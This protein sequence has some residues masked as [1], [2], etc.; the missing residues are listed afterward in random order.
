MQPDATSLMAAL[1]A[2]EVSSSQI[3]RDCL[4]AVE[5]ADRGAFTH[6]DHTH[7]PQLA[8]Q[9]DTRRARGE[10]AG[11]LEGLPVAIKA[12]IAVAGWPHTAGLRFRRDVI[13]PRDAFVVQRLRA[14]GAIPIGLTNMDEGALGAEGMNPWY[15]VIQNPLRRGHSAGGSSGGSGAAVAAGL[16]PV[17]LG[18]DTIGSVRI[19]ASFCGCFG[20]KPSYG[21]V[22]VQDVVPVHL[23]FDHVGPIARSARDL[24][25]LLH[26]LAA[27][28]PACKVSLA[29]RL[30]PA[31][32]TLR[33][34]RVGF[35]IGLEPFHVEDAVQAGFALA[36]DAARGAGADLVPVDLSRWD[37]PRLR[38]AIL[39]L[40]EVQMWRTHGERITAHPDDFSDGLRAFIR[41]G[42]KLGS[43]EIQQAEVSIAAFVADWTR[44]MA[45]LDAVLLPTTACRA[46]PHGERRPQN[47]A[48]LTAL[49]SA[50]GQPAVAMPVWLRGEALPASVQLVGR[51]ASDLQL[52]A[53]AAE[54]Q[55]LLVAGY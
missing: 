51:H 43:D 5:A 16:V 25:M 35:A 32:R 37:L 42:G 12:N 26:A 2:G 49:A 6:V 22:S 38:R 7:A 55:E 19:P 1:A 52:L 15:G 23:R 48:D 31:E 9:S 44:V 8:Q 39:A 36:V 17:A 10:T 21:L 46:F 28:D 30:Q 34:A 54:L 45:N 13:A 3:I 47:T 18:T 33:G 4:E 41:Y 20:L 40:C 53:F 14:A 27:H 50:S 24:S 29:T 11:P